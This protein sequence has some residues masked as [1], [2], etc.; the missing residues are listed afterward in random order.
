MFDISTRISLRL[1]KKIYL[2]LCLKKV[3]AHLQW[4]LQVPQRIL[5]KT[6]AKCNPCKMLEKNPIFEYDN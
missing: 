3:R 4:H 6:V 2:I 1:K 5:K